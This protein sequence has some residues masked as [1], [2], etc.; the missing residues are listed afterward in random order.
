MGDLQA[1]VSFSSSSSSSSSFNP[2]PLSIGVK[3]WLLA[4]QRIQEILCTIQPTAV[5]EQRRKE[6]I[7]YICS[8][9]KDYYGIQVLPFGSVPLKTYLPDGDI[10]LT[11][12]SFENV[13]ED[14]MRDICN[15]LEKEAQKNSEFQVMDVQYIRA[16]VKIVKC[17]VQNIAVDISFNQM[18]GLCALCFLEQVDQL[19]GKNHLFKRSIILIKA[20]CYYESR[21]LGAY[22]G[23]ISTYALET[24]ILSIINLF[25]TSLFSPLA[26]LYRFLDYYS[27]F[28]WDSYCASIVGPVPISSLPEVAMAL[29]NGGDQLLLSEEFIQNC[30]EMFSGPTMVVET[31]AY[32]VP[33]KYLN[34]LDPLKLNNNLGRS[35]S[36]GN[37]Y[38]IRCA[39]SFGARKL[40]QI[41]VLPGE[42]MIEELKK[43]FVNTL[44][45]NGT[46]RRADVEVPVPPFGSGVFEVSDL[47]GPWYH[48]YILSP[49]AHLSSLLSP[50]FRDRNA[51]DAQYQSGHFDCNGFYQR[52]TGVFVPELPFSHPNISQSLDIAKSHAVN[53][54]FPKVKS[55]GTGTYIPATGSEGTGKARGM[56]T[57]LSD[58]NFSHT[59]MHP[60]QRRR[61]PES[62]S[63]GLLREHPQN[64]DQGEPSGT[65]KGGNGNCLNLSLEEFPLLP[66]SKKPAPLGI[67]LSPQPTL[68]P[69][70]VK[71]TSISVEDIEFGTFGLQLSAVG[72]PLQQASKQP[73]SGGSVYVDTVSGVQNVAMQRP[74]M[75][76]MAKDTVLAQVYQ[77]E[78]NEDFPP[79]SR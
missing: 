38:R 68:K 10:D 34:I 29:G 11:T 54:Y 59:E 39:F 5:A 60:R 72:L 65:R 50:Q 48:E 46:G 73:V 32:D 15:V 58:A 4:E 69:P 56:G 8:L 66:Q 43:F 57:L 64:N 13:E 16:Q 25:H 47:N 21:I 20:W 33:L 74:E 61:N 70:Q 37:F 67:P 55:R 1:C 36:K 42:A 14:L 3:C 35:V 41:L 62:A 19:I 40:G 51:C 76:S 7:D 30:R 24:M 17:T 71:D 28:N 77:L 75:L 2:H 53:P 63:H 31:K 52:N 45:R 44:E 9:I 18:A 79:L 22:Y 23:L 27:T 49:S 6:I 78:D 12:L 26:V